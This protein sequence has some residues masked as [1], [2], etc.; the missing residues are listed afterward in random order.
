MCIK[1]HVTPLPTSHQTWW[2]GELL[3]HFSF[4]PSTGNYQFIC[5]TFIR[6]TPVAPVNAMWPYFTSLD[7]GC[8]QFFYLYPLHPAGPG[9][10][11]RWVYTNVCSCFIYY[12]FV[13]VLC[14]F[15]VLL[16]QL[17]CRIFCCP[18]EQMFW[19]VMRLRREMTVAKLGF[20][21]ADQG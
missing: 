14:V 13:F 6:Y 2:Q 1:R 16:K 3:L 9:E 8:L 11:R 20:Y 17:M 5:V 21:L 4:K 15:F 19:E 7:H 12:V 10:T 18:A